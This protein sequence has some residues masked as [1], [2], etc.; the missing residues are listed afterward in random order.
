MPNLKLTDIFFFVLILMRS[1][2]LSEA[3]YLVATRAAVHLLC[4]GCCP[5]HHLAGR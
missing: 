1:E 3:I 2:L 4:A 5:S